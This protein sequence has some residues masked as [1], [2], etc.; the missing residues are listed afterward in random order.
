M[1]YEDVDIKDAKV[2]FCINCKKDPKSNPQ[3]LCNECLLREIWT[4]EYAQIQEEH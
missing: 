3:P 4:S 1:E 2:I